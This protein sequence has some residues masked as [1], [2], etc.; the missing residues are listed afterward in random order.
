M[1]KKLSKKSYS[2]LLCIVIVFASISIQ[3]QAAPM[4]PTINQD[5]VVGELS[6]SDAYSK[7]KS[8]F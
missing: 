8:F 1:F 6:Q 5:S 7:Y 2:V 4:P 3:S